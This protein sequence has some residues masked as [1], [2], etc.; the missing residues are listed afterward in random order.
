MKHLFIF[1]LLF[2]LINLSACDDASAKNK[3]EITIPTDWKIQ[4]TDDFSHQNK[5]WEDYFG[6][7]E[8]VNKA[9]KQTSTEH[10]YPL[11]LREDKTFSDLDISVDFKTISGRI[12]ASAGLVFRAV[13][14]N[15]YYIVRANSLEDNY[16]L[17][18]FKDGS[19]SQIATVTIVP[20]ALGQFHTMRVVAKGNH[21]QAYLNGK[22]WL[23]HHD[24]SFTQGYIGLWTKADAVTEFDNL[25]VLAQ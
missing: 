22:L 25:K 4:V 11:I 1:S 6:E 19:R 20:P 17:Y 24:N 15:N 16:R 13:D 21:I 9:I 7:W 8:F 14:E 23:D 5:A 2:T 10:Y 18:T 3:A 12:D